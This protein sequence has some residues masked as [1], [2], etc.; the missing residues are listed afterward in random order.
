[1]KFEF[2]W[3]FA[4]LIQIKFLK[5]VTCKR[6]KRPLIWVKRQ[7]RRWG[8]KRT[9]TPKFTLVIIKPKEKAQGTRS[10]IIKMNN[11]KICRNRCT[12]K[13]VE[14]LRKKKKKKKESEKCLVHLLCVWVAPDEL[15]QV[16]WPAAIIWQVN[17]KNPEKY[18]KIRKIQMNEY[19]NFAD[20][21]DFFRPILGICY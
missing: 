4:N 16:K 6:T 5:L 10:R 2:F 13:D 3:I 7:V 9:T 15:R 20:F 11:G 8:E 18:G 17:K 14:S 1:M 12:K 21:L 19:L